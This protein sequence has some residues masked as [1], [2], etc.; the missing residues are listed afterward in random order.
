ME[1]GLYLSVKKEGN[2]LKTRENLF[3][4][5]MLDPA[6]VKDVTV[7]STLDLSTI[8][9]DDTFGFDTSTTTHISPHH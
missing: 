8:P 1:L 6:D 7:E 4:F 5:T 2:V 9:D 3:A